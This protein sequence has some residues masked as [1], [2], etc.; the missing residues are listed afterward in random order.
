MFE[1]SLGMIDGDGNQFY[2]EQHGEVNDDGLL[3]VAS[4][5][6]WTVEITAGPDDNDFVK[7]CYHDQCFTCDDNDGGSHGW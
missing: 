5:L 1:F 3:S 2:N 6:P 4:L 7:I